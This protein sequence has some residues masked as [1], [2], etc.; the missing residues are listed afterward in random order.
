VCLMCMQSII[1]LSMSEKNN[2]EQP[3]MAAIRLLKS[4]G[5]CHCDHPPHSSDV[6]RMIKYREE[7]QL[8]VVQ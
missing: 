6:E 2:F 3:K 8:R 5:C 7:L 4:Q 1:I